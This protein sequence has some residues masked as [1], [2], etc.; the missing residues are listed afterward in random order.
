[1][2]KRERIHTEGSRGLRRAIRENNLTLEDAGELL[3][4]DRFSVWRWIHGLN[5]PELGAVVAIEDVFK[6]SVRAWLQRC[7][8]VHDS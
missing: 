4:V 2:K 3:G 1:M 8:R 6:V 5:T 7:T